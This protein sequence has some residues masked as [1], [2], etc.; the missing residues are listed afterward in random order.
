MSGAPGRDRPLPAAYATFAPVL[1]QLSVPLRQLVGGQLAQF[2]Q[3]LAGFDETELRSDGDF[4][5]LGSLATRGDMAHIVQ[6]ELLLR[7]EAPLEFLRRVAESE[8]L[9]HEREYSDPGARPVF[10][11]M[12]SVGPG[13]LGHGR[14]LALAAIFFMARVAAVRDAAFHW[15]FLPRPEGAIW[16][17]N[18]S[19]NTIKRFL[20]AAS[21]IEAS[22]DDVAAAQQCWEG[23]AHAL[24]VAAGARTIDW[25]VGAADSLPAEQSPRATRHAPRVI[26][27]GLLPPL[28]GAPRAAEITIRRRGREVRRAVLAFPADTVCLSALNQPFAPIKPVARSAGRPE[29]AAQPFGWEPRYLVAPH[30]NAKILRVAHGVL[31][32]I[33]D[34][35]AKLGASYFLRIEADAKLAGVRL[36]A[37]NQLAVLLQT[38][39]SG[40]DALM[41]TSV[42]LSPGMGSI[43]AE[44]VRAHR[45]TA[46][47][48]FKRQPDFALPLLFDGY[49][50]RF[51]STHRREFGL[52]FAAQ[53]YEQ[54]LQVPQNRPQILYANG[55]HRVM[56]DRSRG[57]ASLDVMRNNNTMVVSYPYQ[58]DPP[59]P[60]RLLGMV[61][62]G[63]HGSLAYSTRPNVWAVAGR[64][65]HREFVVAPYEIPLMGRIKDDVMDA[66]VWSDARGGGEGVLRSISFKDDG[67]KTNRSVLRS[68]RTLI[69]LGND[70]EDIAEVRLGDDGVWA[71]AVDSG[72]APAELRCYA[73][74]NEGAHG[75]RRFDLAELA[76]GAIDIDPDRI[77]HG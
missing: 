42:D 49:G 19:V 23:L 71:V 59:D 29:K 2:E 63:S 54:T 5:G 40:N 69:R 10:R 76:A 48:L 27:F 47:H 44:N 4:E 43:G 14:I 68:H 16:F 20:R 1:D 65:A 25:V 61:Y 7:T 12:I 6:S 57:A 45:T 8:V 52:N 22:L 15:C 51:Y 75:C 30:A 58:D 39:R 18:L 46:Q 67:H 31:I 41:L 17:D 11:L 73:R 3:L 74:R 9:Y 26:A 55:V 28:P 66:T 36:R 33:F 21:Y 64:E 13:L 37:G 62:S 34:R 32:L 53:G 56:L 50:T 70:A 24:P 72:G 60:K 38:A 35:G 77:S